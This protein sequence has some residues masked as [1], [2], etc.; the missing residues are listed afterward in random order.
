MAAINFLARMTHNA[1]G[2]FTFCGTKD[3]RGETVQNIVV[4]NVVLKALKGLENK[5]MTQNGFEVK[6]S[7]VRKAKDVLKLGDHFGNKFETI[8][9]LLKINSIELLQ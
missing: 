2:N 9:R 5:K 7:N 4:K 8:L 6:I 3:K 1:I